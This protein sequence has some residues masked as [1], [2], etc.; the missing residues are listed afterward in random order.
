[1][2]SPQPHPQ[3]ATARR[4]AWIVLITSAAVASLL[5]PACS[6]H[7]AEDQQDAAI[8]DE[9][10]PS[11][12]GAVED[13]QDLLAMGLIG[14]A[15]DF[16]RADGE[17]MDLCTPCHTPHVAL[18]RASWRDH[19]GPVHDSIRPY[20]ADGV[21]LDDSSLLCLSCHDGVFASDV[22]SFAHAITPGRQL[23]GS[24][25]G[26]GS[27]TS[28][29]VGVRYPHSEGRYHPASIV[30][31]DERIKLPGGRVQCIS[32]H[33]PHNTRRMGGMLVSSNEGSRLC[34]ACHD[35]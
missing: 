7:L 29:P 6:R 4:A 35:L 2:E 15:H 30:T 33:D 22:F 13:V 31:A 25:I 5:G 28:H 11:K 10:A 21:E 1:M 9:S 19:G 32:C 14:S 27:L 3:A 18:H 16:R 34:L 20:H 24:W 17:P 26:P 8:R 12:L 23:A